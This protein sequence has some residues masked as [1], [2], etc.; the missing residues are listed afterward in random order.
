MI[1]CQPLSDV[2]SAYT[3]TR[4]AATVYYRKSTIRVTAHLNELRFMQH[5]FILHFYGVMDAKWG[6]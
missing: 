5:D 1:T 3:F 4:S 2:A 6:K